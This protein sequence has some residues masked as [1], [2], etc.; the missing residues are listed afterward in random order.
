MQRME[1][2]ESGCSVHLG[3]DVTR[4]EPVDLVQRDHDGNAD[5]E[6]APRDESVARADALT[7]GQHEENAFDVLERRFDGALH[8]LGKRVERPLE[9]GQIREDELVIV[10]V[11]DPEDAPS[12]GLRLVGDERDLPA[13][14]R[15][16]EH[17]LADVRAPGNG[18]E[19]GS[20]AGGKSQVSGSSSAA[21]YV[22]ISPT[23]LRNVTS[24]IPN[25]YSHC[26]QPPHGDAV[27][28]IAAMSPGL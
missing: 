17:G 19:A 5:S 10:A 1:V 3:C 26:R 14:Q 15:V 9:A 25:S 12:G 27:M 16:D 21:A 20:H 28:P 24:S 11:R 18:H 6:H 13:A 22:T 23:A 2:A 7:R 4:L 8:V